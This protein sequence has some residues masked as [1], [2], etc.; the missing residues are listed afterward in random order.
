MIQASFERQEGTDRILR[1]TVS[2]H[3]GFDSYGYDI[4]C[5]S[6]SALVITTINT[7]EEYV[8]LTCDVSVEEGFTSIAVE[9]IDEHTEIQSQAVLHALEIGLMGLKEEYEDFIQVES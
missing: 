9:A 2:G 7:L 4:V 1:A 3:A 6:V 8:G 5:A